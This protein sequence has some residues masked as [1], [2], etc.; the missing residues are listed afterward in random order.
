MWL[1]VAFSFGFSWI[2]GGVV[3]AAGGIGSDSP[4]LFAGV[5][6]WDALLAVY[7]FGPAIG[8]VLTRIV[9]GEGWRGLRSGMK[10]SGRP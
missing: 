7:M 5:R 4:E 6:L 3:Y 10:A 1:F 9:T 2:V 8:N